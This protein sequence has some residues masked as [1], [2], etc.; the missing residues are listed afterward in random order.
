[1]SPFPVVV[2]DTT[3]LI[4]LAKIEL[5]E[6]LPEL[7]GEILVPKAV[8][9]EVVGAGKKRSGVKAVAEADW[10]IVQEVEDKSRVDYLLTQ[11]DLGEA[12]AIILAQEVQAGL[13]LVDERKARAI[14][15]RLNLEVVGTA[16][17]LLLLKEQAV[18]TEVRPLLNKLRAL[19]FRLGD[20]VYNYII[21]QAG[22]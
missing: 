8:Y 16:G 9:D 19:D 20:R 3:P 6:M 4:A 10:I 22:E 11:L 7:F 15:Q 13:V 12:E 1:M 21:L 18:I 2:S 14:A 17:L 5:L